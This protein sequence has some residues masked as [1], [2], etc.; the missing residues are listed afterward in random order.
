MAYAQTRDILH[1]QHIMGHRSI[2]NTVRY[3]HLIQYEGNDQ[4]IC[5]VAKSPDEAV[6]LVENGFDFVSQFPDG[7]QLYRRRK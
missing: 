5:K 6:K 4:F 7:I 2:T 3:T 1:V